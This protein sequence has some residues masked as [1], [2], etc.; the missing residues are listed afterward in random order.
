MGD[1]ATAARDAEPT[2]ALV[3]FILAV[4]CVMAVL[5]WIKPL[6]PHVEALGDWLA[7][8]YDERNRESRNRDLQ[9]PPRDRD[10]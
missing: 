6:R 8:K 2:P 9:S 1:G 4:F 5:M 10:W 3:A 7:Q